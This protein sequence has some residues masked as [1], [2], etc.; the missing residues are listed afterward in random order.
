LYKLRKNYEAKAQKYLEEAIR[1]VEKGLVN[2]KIQQFYE[3]CYILTDMI[4]DGMARSLSLRRL[5]EHVIIETKPGSVEDFLKKL[6][7]Y[8]KIDQ[9]KSNYYFVATSNLNIDKLSQKTF[10]IMK[11][12]IRLMKFAEA[13]KEFGISNLFKEWHLFTREQKSEFLRNTPFYVSINVE[14]CTPGEAAEK[15]FEIFELF[16]GLLNFASHYGKI[17][18]I[19]YGGIPNPKTLS[20]MEPA[21]VQMIFDEQKNHLFDRFT[22]GF[23]DYKEKRFDYHREKFLL[24]LIEK[25]NSLEDCPLAKRCISAFRKYNNGLDGNVAGTSFLE[26]WK[27]LEW[28]ALSDVEEGRMPESKVAKRISSFF[29][30]DFKRDLLHALCNKRNFITHVGSLSE[31]DQNEMNMI[32]IFCEKAM[33]FLLEKANDFKDESTLNYYYEFLHK[34]NTDLERIERVICEIKRLRDK[35]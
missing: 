34:N 20:T 21:R 35:N 28:I 27:I 26:F 18:R 16:R 3:F 32:K 12:K 14:A 4:E 23:F 25:I 15:G 2:E 29:K 24:Y 5:I 13:N 17:T 11:T 31:F 30:T 8:S 10:E 9:Q 6:N 1:L 7:E 19:S 33:I 22:I